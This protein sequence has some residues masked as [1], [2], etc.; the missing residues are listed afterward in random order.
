MPAL[1]LRE[2]VVL[3]CDLGEQCPE[4]AHVLSN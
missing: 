2:L 1:V 4:R 3:K